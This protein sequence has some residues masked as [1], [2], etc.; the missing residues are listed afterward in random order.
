MIGHIIAFILG[1]AAHIS[2]PYVKLLIEKIV[3]KG[4]NKMDKEIDRWN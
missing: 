4:Y 3:K 1:Y 2:V